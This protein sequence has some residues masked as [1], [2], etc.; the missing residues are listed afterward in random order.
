MDPIYLPYLHK[1]GECHTN[2]DGQVVNLKG[3]LIHCVCVRLGRDK[4]FCTE[5][6]PTIKEKEERKDCT[7]CVCFGYDV[8][9]TTSFAR[10]YVDPEATSR[11]RLVLLPKETSS[12][13]NQVPLDDTTIYSQETFGSSQANSHWYGSSAL[14]EES[15]SSGRARALDLWGLLLYIIDK[16]KNLVL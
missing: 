2:M 12:L 14:V 11:S 1:M 3:L 10:T 16:H 8:F 5:E 9:L 4:N 13:L 7:V 15:V 6:I